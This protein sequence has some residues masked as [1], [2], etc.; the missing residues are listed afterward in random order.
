M[1]A[2]IYIG[3]GAPRLTVAKAEIDLP[4]PG[5]PVT[6]YTLD[7]PIML[8]FDDD[9]ALG[10]VGYVVRDPDG[11]PVTP[12]GSLVCALRFIARRQIAIERWSCAASIKSAASGV[13]ARQLRGALA[14]LQALIRIEEGIEGQPERQSD[15]EAY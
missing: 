13:A 14:G 4:L 6:V 15:L 12:W 9:M 2:T 10:M 11:H 3:R 5:E 7:G 1:K 8:T